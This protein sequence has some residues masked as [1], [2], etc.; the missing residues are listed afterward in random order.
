MILP[1]TTDVA[2][3]TNPMNGCKLMDVEV[4]EFKLGGVSPKPDEPSTDAGLLEFNIGGVTDPGTDP[5]PDEVAV[6]DGV[7]AVGGDRVVAVGGDGVC[8]DDVGYTHAPLLGL[9]VVI[10]ALPPKSQLVCTGFF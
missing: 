7:V 4:D 9:V 1:A 10:I 3:M 2:R 8:D 6:G 5:S